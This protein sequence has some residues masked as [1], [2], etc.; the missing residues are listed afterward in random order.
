MNLAQIDFLKGRYPNVRIGFFHHED[1]ANTDIIKL[2]IA[3]VQIFLKHVGLP[4][5]QY[6]LNAYSANPHQVRAWLSAAREAQ[7]FMG[8]AATAFP[9]PQKKLP[10]CAP[11]GGLFAKRP[12]KAGERLQPSDFYFAFP[13]AEGQFTANDC[14]KYAAF[15]VTAD[16]QT[17]ALITPVMP[18]APTTTKKSGTLRRTR[19]LLKQSQVAVPLTADLEIPTTMAWI[20]LRRPD[21]S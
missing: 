13:P 14:S 16:I 4:T 8:L 7:V 20:S 3:R 12:L 10:A 1:P 2:A 17:D 5:A 11:S 21:S 19:A 15:D 9:P 18:S 6:P